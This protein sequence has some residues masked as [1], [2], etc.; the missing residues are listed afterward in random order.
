MNKP[1]I[2]KAMN[3]WTGLVQ[4]FFQIRVQA[5]LDTVGNDVFGIEFYWIRYK[6]APSRGQIHPH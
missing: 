4:E 6:F 1:G 3:D 5:W 2:V